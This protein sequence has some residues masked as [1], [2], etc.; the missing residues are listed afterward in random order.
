MKISVRTLS[1]ALGL[2]A[3]SSTGVAAQ[4][5]LIPSSMQATC[6]GTT[7]ERIEF[8]LNVLGDVF[9]DHITLTSGDESLWRFG[10][11][12]QVL[13]GQG[14]DVTAG[15]GTKLVDGGIELVSHTY[16]PWVY[17]SD[18]LRLTVQM[19]QFGSRWNLRNEGAVSYTAFGDRESSTNHE[20]PFNTMGTATVAPEP[21]TWFLLGTGLLALGFLAWRRRDELMDRVNGEG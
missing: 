16:S 1:L 19:N 11:V 9:V 7:C 13:D 17:R 18:P 6:L 14:N 2:L 21:E 20:A 3:V 15:Y 8:Q 12:L 10:T 4:R 5:G